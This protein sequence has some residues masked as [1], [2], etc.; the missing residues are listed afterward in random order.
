MK[1]NKYQLISI[2]IIITILLILVGLRLVQNTEK[3]YNT[4]DNDGRFFGTWVN[5][6]E[7]SE[8]NLNIPFY[9]S[10]TFNSNGTGQTDNRTFWW[11]NYKHNNSLNFD[12]EFYYNNEMHYYNCL[13]A[14]SEGN[15]KLTFRQYLNGEWVTAIYVKQ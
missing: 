5:E 15:N 11:C 8:Y 7:E 13:I 9:N 1:I 3:K 6:T 2:A 12:L 14:F 10:Y 4:A